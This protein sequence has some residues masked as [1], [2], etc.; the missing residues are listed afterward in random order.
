MATSRE[1]PGGCAITSLFLLVLLLP[2]IGSIVLTF[3]ILGDE[4]NCGEKTLWL[5]LVWVVPV[6][7]P[8]LYLLLG[9]RRN[10]VLPA[11]T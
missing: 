7:G 4:M 9:Q 10:R 3:M 2:V 8:L 6:V 1:G 11:Y 5:V